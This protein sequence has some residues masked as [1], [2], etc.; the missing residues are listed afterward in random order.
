MPTP[1]EQALAALYA[2]AGDP[3]ITSE[4]FESVMTRIERLEQEDST[5]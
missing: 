1:K 2:K 3:S 4:E 5:A